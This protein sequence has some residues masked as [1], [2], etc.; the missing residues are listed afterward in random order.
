MRKVIVDEP[1]LGVL[2]QQ[3]VSLET[4]L[5]EGRT[6]IL[7][8]VA[9][10]STGGVPV[11]I[12]QGI[13]PDNV[14][15]AIN[16]AN[17]L[18]LDLAGVDLILP[19]ISKS[20]L[21][22]GGVICEVNAQPQLGI[23]TQQHVYGQLLKRWIKRDGRIPVTCLIGGEDSK[24]YHKL[25]AE[26]EG[27]RGVGWV[28]SSGARIDK[29]RLLPQGFFDLFQA[30][31]LNKSLEK[32]VA[33]LPESI[34]KTGLPV[35]MIDLLCVFEVDTSQVTRQL[36]NQVSVYAKRVCMLDSC[37]QLNLSHSNLEMFSEDGLLSQ[38]KN[39]H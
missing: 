1:M 30:L 38:I 36:I 14:S 32:I 7:S 13:H 19:D 27:S 39:S 18:R 4:C 37:K 35:D 16:A 15:L 21:K 25:M 12:T 10:V 22:T 20:W 17:A 5:E 29:N 2:K 26:L 24:F 11:A 33:I 23:I 31:F 34:L 9:N 6:I 28:D 3:G 8:F